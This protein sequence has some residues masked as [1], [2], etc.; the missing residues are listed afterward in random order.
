[1]QPSTKAVDHAKWRCSIIFLDNGRICLVLMQLG[2]V[3]N[4]KSDDM[5]YKMRLDRINSTV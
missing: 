3:N 2:C 1:M 5:E 4:I